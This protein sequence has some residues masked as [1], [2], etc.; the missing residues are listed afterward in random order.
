LFDGS[1]QL[2]TSVSPALRPYAY[3][4]LVTAN[5]Q[6]ELTSIERWRYATTL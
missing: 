1:R 5:G 4:L 6:S 2:A 3:M